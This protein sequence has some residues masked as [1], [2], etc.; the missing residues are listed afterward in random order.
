MLVHSSRKV[1][2]FQSV[3]Q[4]YIKQNVH[5]NFD[6]VYRSIKVQKNACIINLR[7]RVCKR[8]IWS[9]CTCHISWAT[10]DYIINTYM[11]KK[12]T[13]RYHNYRSTTR[14]QK[15]SKELQK[16]PRQ[17]N[18]MQRKFFSEKKIAKK[19]KKFRASSIFKPI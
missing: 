2:R 18:V 12:S 19:K 6:H 16:I 14:A 10:R 15:A 1:C 8:Y 17:K 4:K 3:S 9:S 11:Q 7:T 13:S 5:C